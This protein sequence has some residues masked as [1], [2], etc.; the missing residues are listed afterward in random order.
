V[1]DA[2][3]VTPTT[4]HAYDLLAHGVRRRIT[5]TVT[6]TSPSPPPS[7]EQ[8]PGTWQ[9]LV[10]PVQT[11]YQPLLGGNSTLAEE[12]PGAAY[13]TC[14]RPIQTNGAGIVR[15]FSGALIANGKLL[16]NGGGHVGTPRQ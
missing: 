9:K 13:T 1:D 8:A 2:L 4:T 7:W 12:A 6:T 5:V 11:I 14:P 16:V 10:F 3:T 15:S